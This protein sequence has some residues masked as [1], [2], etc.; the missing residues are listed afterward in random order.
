VEQTIQHIIPESNVTE[1]QTKILVVDDEESVR[2]TLTEL[3]QIRNFRVTATESAEQALKLLE[4]NAFDVVLSDLL[5]PR[6]DG[7]ALAKTIKE[8]GLNVPVVVMTGYASIET[9]VESMKAGAS[10][11]ITKPFNLDQI[12]IVIN[13]TLENKKLQQLAQEREYFEH[14]SNTDGLTEL[15]NHRYF[16]NVL[17]IEVERERR[18]KRPLSLL[19]IDID[20]FKACNDMHGHLMG[21][22]VLQQ[23]GTLVKKSTRGCDYVAR[24]GGEEF[25]VILPETTK[26][27]ALV[28]AER[29]RASIAE[30][31]FTTGT[32]KSIG[33]VTVTIGL[34]SFPDDAQDRVE[35]IDKADK[36]LYQGKTSGKNRICA[37]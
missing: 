10:D 26:Q 19:M 15:Y 20:N 11:F 36:S 4:Q 8:M 25:A 29:I 5:M 2:H 23:V 14:L 34:S 17:N 24:Y 35:L 31:T 6:V 7:I 9:A 13:R 3:L 22:V 21:D 30:H 1:G 32:G 37:G 33:N 28:V 18:Y 27:E 12:T 16:Q